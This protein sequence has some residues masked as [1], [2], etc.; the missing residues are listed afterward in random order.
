VAQIIDATGKA[1]PIP[2][3]MA[4][5]LIDAQESHFT[6]YVD[7][8]PAVENLKR[9]AKTQGFATEVH[10]EN[11]TYHV[12]FS[13]EGEVDAQQESEKKSQEKFVPGTNKVLYIS[14]D[15][16]GAGDAALGKNLLRMFL[17][18]VDQREELPQTILM[19]NS[20]IR[21]ATEDS[22]SIETLKALHEKGV[23]ILVCGTCLDFYGMLDRLQVGSVCTMYDITERL[24]H[25]DIVISV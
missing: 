13:R 10:E 4:K 16:M 17:Y 14:R 22:Q 19:L 12:Q 15:T 3:I 20:G 21:M 2:F 18:S 7:N 5:K 9:L 11:Q 6:V 8:R 23:E 25:A 24:F 1:C